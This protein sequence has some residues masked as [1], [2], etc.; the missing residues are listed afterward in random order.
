MLSIV[1]EA[2]NGIREVG[3]CCCPWLRK[4]RV[5]YRSKQMWVERDI[6]AYNRQDAARRIDPKLRAG[7][8]CFVVRVIG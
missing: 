3:S 2:M 8:N 1:R 5:S 6:L 7:Y 4:F